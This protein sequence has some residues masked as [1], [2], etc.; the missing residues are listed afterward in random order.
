MCGNCGE[1]YTA[2]YRGGRIYIE[3][4]KRFSVYPILLRRL[5]FQRALPRTSQATSNTGTP[6][7]LGQARLET[8]T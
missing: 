1:E 7:L 8:L 3:A 5:T 2:S 4:K 6:T